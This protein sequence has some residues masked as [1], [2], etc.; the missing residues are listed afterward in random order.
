M[1]SSPTGR[2]LRQPQHPLYGR[3]GAR[4]LLRWHCGHGDGGTAR[5][6]PEQ[7]QLARV[8][9]FAAGTEDPFDQKINLLAQERV[10]PAQDGPFS[11]LMLKDTSA[12]EIIMARVKGAIHFNFESSRPR[13]RS[14]D[15][16]CLDTAL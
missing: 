11:P 13:A 6:G 14:G 5:I 7:L 3:T 15:R 4:L 8:E 12:H 16:V 9:L 10:L 1:T 2:F